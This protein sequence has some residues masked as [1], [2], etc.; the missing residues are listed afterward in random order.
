MK[1]IFL[2]KVISVLS[3]TMLL[4]FFLINHAL[5]SADA[6]IEIKTNTITIKVIYNVAEEYKDSED[7]YIRNPSRLLFDLINIFQSHSEILG[8]R[9]NIL[10]ELNRNNNKTSLLCVLN[11]EKEY[12]IVYEAE[13]TSDIKSQLIDLIYKMLE[14]K[15]SQ[16]LKKTIVLYPCVSGRCNGVIRFGAFPSNDLNT[17]YSII[18]ESEKNRRSG[19]VVRRIDM[20]KYFNFIE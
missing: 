12:N 7:L 6:G 15:N 2:I 18:S 11:P 1:K 20:N 17:K 3:C 14:I 8:I 9:K 4:S 16:T 5:S 13:L 19:V 10:I